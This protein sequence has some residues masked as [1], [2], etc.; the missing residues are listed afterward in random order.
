MEYKKIVNFL[1]KT[2]NQPSKFR[3]KN[4]VE[5]NDDAH[6]KHNKNSQIKF[7]ISMLKSS[8]CDYNDAYILISETI[9]TDGAGDDDNAKRLDKGNKGV[10]FENCSP[11]ADC[12][13][14]INNTPIDNAKDIML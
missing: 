1:D 10:I 2:P 7:K 13:N 5:I 6:G 4:A 12:I 8:L 9:T 11:F 14:E 3:T